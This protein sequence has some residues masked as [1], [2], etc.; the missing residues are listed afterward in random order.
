MREENNNFFMSALSDF[1][2]DIA[3]G[4]Q[5]RHLADLGHPASQIVTELDVTVPYERVQQTVTEHLCKMGV[6]LVDKPGSENS[7]KTKFIREYDSYG[8]PSF[9]QITETGTEAA[10]ISWQKRIFRYSLSG[11]FLQ[12]LNRKTEENGEEN[13]FISCDFGLGKEKMQQSLK[14]LEQ[15]QR[16]YIESI[17]WEKSRMYYQL[18]PFIRTLM[19]RLYECGCYDGE[20]YLKKTREHVVFPRRS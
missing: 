11:E 3:C 14:V 16:A 13:S 17:L 5:I 18:T 7:A 12:F 19:S 8:R 6:L 9:R 1:T 2:Y 10:E 20:C 4:A 15:K